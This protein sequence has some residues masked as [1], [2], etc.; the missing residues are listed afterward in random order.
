M[1]KYTTPH[2]RSELA[3]LSPRV[4]RGLWADAWHYARCARNAARTNPN[5]ANRLIQ[6]SWERCGQ[7][8]T[9][10]AFDALDERDSEM[11]YWPTTTQEDS[12]QQRENQPAQ[13]QAN[14]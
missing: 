7:H 10:L 13:G 2:T 12:M 4:L 5:E 8:L 9:D 6:L 3:K 14:A 1:N 11:H